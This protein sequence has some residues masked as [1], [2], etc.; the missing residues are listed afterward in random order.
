MPRRTNACK[1]YVLHTLVWT[2]LPQSFSSKKR[3]KFD[4]KLARTPL[5]DELLETHYYICGKVVAKSGLLT[6][7][8]RVFCQ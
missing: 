8:V 3:P 7:I 4:K 1:N 2:A 6:E 5:S